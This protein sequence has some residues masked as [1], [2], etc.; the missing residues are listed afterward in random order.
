MKD[1][2]SSYEGYE[3]YEIVVY[4]NYGVMLLWNELTITM[5]MSMNKF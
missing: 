4:L 5:Y 1:M 3:G 2:D